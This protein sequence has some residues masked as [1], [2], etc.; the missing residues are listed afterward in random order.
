MNQKRYFLTRKLVRVI[1]GINTRVIFTMGDSGWCV[2]IQ[3]Y[4]H[5]NKVHISHDIRTQ[6]KSA[7]DKN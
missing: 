1:E 3:T 2:T 6:D 7:P 5:T 4:K